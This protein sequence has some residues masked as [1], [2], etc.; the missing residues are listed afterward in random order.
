MHN[1]LVN[2]SYQ[3]VVVGGSAGSL[4]ALGTLLN[5]LP[6]DFGLPIIVVL[7]TGASDM[8]D[9]V[10]LLSRH[11]KLR[12]SEARER[13]E[14][15][16]GR[17]YLAPGRYHLLI[18][19]DRHFSLSADARVRYSRPS[20]DVLFESAADAYKNKLIAVVLTGA[21]EDGAA[22]AA[23]IKSLGG[24]VLVQD[25]KTAESATMPE[26]T[27]AS[28]H[29]DWVGSMDKMSQQLI[30]VARSPCEAF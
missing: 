3:A 6:A 13:E 16:P 21:N 10:I 11:S 26:S 27:I 4:T 23:R 24:V 28:A 14:I 19:R 12:V 1:A 20:I 8:S 17:V 22:G 25:P 2:N 7:H 18:E 29:P 30:D 9:T 15:L 5:G